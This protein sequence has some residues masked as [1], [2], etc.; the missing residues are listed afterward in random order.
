[1]L[2]KESLWIVKNKG[3]GGSAW[4]KFDNENVMVIFQLQCL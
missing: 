3:V 4:Q 2:K 1:M